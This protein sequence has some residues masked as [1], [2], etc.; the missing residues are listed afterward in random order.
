MLD[1]YLDHGLKIEDKTIKLIHNMK[2]VKGQDP[3]LS[4]KFRRDNKVK[5]KEKNMVMFS[6]S[7]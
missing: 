5:Q 4:L 2:K 7:Y 6:L 1:W 3:I